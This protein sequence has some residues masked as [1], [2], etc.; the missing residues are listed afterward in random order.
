MNFSSHYGEKLKISFPNKGFK[1]L[2]NIVQRNGSDIH[3]RAHSGRTIQS[4][5]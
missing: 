4:G 3:A 2:A 5:Y 1:A